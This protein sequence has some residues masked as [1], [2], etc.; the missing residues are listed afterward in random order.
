MN[1]EK[2]R[3]AVVRLDDE[4]FFFV[5]FHQFVLRSDAYVVVPGGIGTEPVRSVKN[6]SAARSA[7]GSSQKLTGGLGR[8][9]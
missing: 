3:S 4:E 6:S 8:Q 2:S 9:R 5:R 7:A 1:S